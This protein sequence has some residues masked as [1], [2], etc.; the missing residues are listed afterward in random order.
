VG[1]SVSKLEFVERSL[2]LDFSALGRAYMRRA[3]TLTGGARRFTDKL[4]LN[5]LYAGL[6]HASLPHARFVALRR[7]PVAVCFAMYRTLFASVLSIYL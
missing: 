2:E 1:G 5:Y 4:P 7:H 3:H 6:I